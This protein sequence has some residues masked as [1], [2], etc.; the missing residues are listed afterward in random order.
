MTNPI[1]ISDV[2][3]TLA[4]V[5]KEF[6]DNLKA[7]MPN[8]NYVYDEGLSY[9]TAIK[10]FVSDN[11]N[12]DNPQVPLPLFAF[13]RSVLRRVVDSATGRRLSSQRVTKSIEGS[14]TTVSELKALHGEFDIEFLYINRDIDQLER[15]EILYNVE[16]G[17]IGTRK[18]SVEVGDLGMFD[19]F[20]TDKDGLESKEIVNESVSYKAVQSVFSIRGFFLTF[21]TESKVIL[22]VQSEIKTYLEEQLG[23][24]LSNA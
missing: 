12:E 15:F 20:V 2:C 24:T 21:K 11:N 23:V 7:V 8:V 13:R 5:L 17:F 6:L 9:E 4:P 10:K 19:Y 14:D 16:E 3:G 18:L 1:Q 22:E